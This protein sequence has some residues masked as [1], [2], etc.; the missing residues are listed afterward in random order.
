VNTGAIAPSSRSSFMIR[1][2]KILLI[3]HDEALARALG[4]TLHDQGFE[5]SHEGDPAAL[6]R[7]A[8]YDCI[9][10]D[11][12]L[13][14]RERADVWCAVRD[15]CHIPVVAITQLGQTER[16]LPFGQDYL[17]KPFQPSELAMRIGIALRRGESGAP[18]CT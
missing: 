7:G 13:P 14:G 18:P 9:V 10:V 2:L 17:V 4:R 15:R 11:L 5:V 3:E 6:A 8:P 1:P 12:S 16:V